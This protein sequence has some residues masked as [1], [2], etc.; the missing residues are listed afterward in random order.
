MGFGKAFT[1]TLGRGGLVMAD[2]VFVKMNV[3][4]GMVDLAFW[5]LAMAY[6]IWYLGQ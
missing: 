4:Y 3:L 6:W 5:I 2:L 1:P